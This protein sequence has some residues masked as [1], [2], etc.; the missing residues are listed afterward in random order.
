MWGKSV[1][2]RGNSAAAGS[3]FR[4]GGHDARA[5]NLRARFETERHVLELFLGWRDKVMRFTFTTEAALAGMGGWMYT[6]EV[7]GLAALPFVLGVVIGAVGIG[8]DVRIQGILS[9]CYERGSKL[10]LELGQEDGG[11]FGCIPIKSRRPLKHLATFHF[12]LKL[13]FGITASIYLYI[14]IWVLLNAPRPA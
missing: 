1:R 8:L 6:N 2:K 4:R 14:A 3:R 9:D 7:G 10:A 13:A 5:E 11:P 12:L